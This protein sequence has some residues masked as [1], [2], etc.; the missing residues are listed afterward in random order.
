MHQSA[1]GC[2]LLVSVVPLSAFTSHRYPLTTGSQA[3]DYFVTSAAFGNPSDSDMSSFTEQVVHF[4]SH[5]LLPVRNE[6]TLQS[7]DPF[8]DLLEAQGVEDW[9]TV[10][11]VHTGNS[12]RTVE[13]AQLLVSAILEQDPQGIVAFIRAGNE[14]LPGRVLQIT[15]DTAAQR[16]QLYQYA[17]VVV[18]IALVCS[19]QFISETLSTCTPVVTDASAARH[20]LML[21]GIYGSVDAQLQSKTN[22][23]AVADTAVKAVRIATTGKERRG[24]R[25]ALCSA[26]DELFDPTELQAEWHTFLGNAV[27]PM[28]ACDQ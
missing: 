11:L 8:P 16:L 28:T 3:V 7:L 4:D 9:D 13:R 15:A 24:L 27:D 6:A 26:R 19:F 23:T 21:P 1:H 10:Y 22:G 17:S 14:T 18:D 20:A 2:F 5:V 25:K 12:Q